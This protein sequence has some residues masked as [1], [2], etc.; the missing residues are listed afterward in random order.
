M[1]WGEGR[2]STDD[3]TLHYSEYQMIDRM[4]EEFLIYGVDRVL[5]VPQLRIVRDPV[6]NGVKLVEEVF[7]YLFEVE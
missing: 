6:G 5:T 1:H 7:K 4:G 3:V 2:D